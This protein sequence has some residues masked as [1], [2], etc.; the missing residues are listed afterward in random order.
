MPTMQIA[1]AIQATESLS[2]A[3]LCDDATIDYTVVE[4]DVS[5]TSR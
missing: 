2:S 3:M 5:Q 4:V 1:E